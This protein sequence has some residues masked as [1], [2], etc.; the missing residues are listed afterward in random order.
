MGGAEKSEGQKGEPSQ[1]NSKENNC[2]MRGGGALRGRGR[3]SCITAKN[4][5]NRPD[6]T[7][8]WF[9]KHTVNG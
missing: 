9:A 8:G 4:D 7:G 2:G 6:S 3:L 1:A 5:K